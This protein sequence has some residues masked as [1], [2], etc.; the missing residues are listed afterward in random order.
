MFDFTLTP[1]PPQIHNVDFEEN[2]TTDLIEAVRSG[3]KRLIFLGKLNS[4]ETLIREVGRFVFMSLKHVFQLPGGNDALI[5]N[6]PMYVS[7]LGRNTESIC[8]HR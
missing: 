3:E 6:P 5:A 7:N 4:A 8:V 2:A 1:S